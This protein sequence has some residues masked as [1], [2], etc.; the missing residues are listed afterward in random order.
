MSAPRVSVIMPVYNTERY[1]E[2][3]IRSVLDQTYPDLELVVVDDG[4]RDSSLEICRRFTDPRVLVVTQENR[5]LAAARNAGLRQSHGEYVGILDSDD[6]WIDTKL[7]E[8]VRFLESHPGVGVSFS[9]SVL[10]DEDGRPLGM[11]KG[12]KVGRVQASDV[13]LRDP[14]LPSSVVARRQTFEDVSFSDDRR[15]DPETAYFDEDFRSCVDAECWLR[16]ALTTPWGFEGLPAVL[17]LYRANP[18]GLSADLDRISASWEQCVEKVRGYAP[19]FVAEWAGLGRAFQTRY[20]A[21]RAIRA[22]DG[23]RALTLAWSSIR[24]DPRMLRME[25]F[26]TLTTLSAAVALAA[27]PRGAYRRLEAAGMR[28]SGRLQRLSRPSR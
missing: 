12:T 25:P 5:G 18:E 24:Q 6:L 1:V 3:A 15:G 19:D 4:S 9:R 21:R 26:T 14:V 28:V 16:I 8:H 17:T 2:G 22:R 23:R 20:V 10:I 7:E 27:L 13:L 11:D